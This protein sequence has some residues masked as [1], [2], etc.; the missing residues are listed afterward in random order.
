MLAI[1]KQK[2]SSELTLK[3]NSDVKKLQINLSDSIKKINKLNINLK[4]KNNL[5]NKLMLNYNQSL[6]ILKRNYNLNLQIIN[7]YDSNFPNKTT[8]FTNKKLLI[9]GLNYANTQYELNGC[10]DD[11]KKMHEFLSSKGFIT[12]DIL[13]DFTE[14]KPTKENILN[15]IKD[16][17]NSS[18]E[19]D[20]L[21]IY[22]SG[23][24][25]S[26]YDNS[27]D[28]LDG[29]DEM[30]VSL[31]LQGV[32]DDEIQNILKNNKNVTIIGLF[33]SCHSGTM[34]DLKY[35]YDIPNNN[36]IENTNIGFKEI[37]N[38]NILMI[39][40]CLDNQYSSEALINNKIQGAMTW[41][42]IDI[43]S[44]SPN[45][46]WSF[47]LKNMNKLLNENGYQQNP[48]LSTNKIY[49]IDSTIFL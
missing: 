30:I 4:S 9:F 3:F 24:G 2:K 22:F 45:C 25:S 12:Y 41:S 11:A 17:I 46:S 27:N 32:Y 42:F 26:T 40:G 37:L 19:G 39:S 23:H 47:L 38:G 5:I 44:N 20:L 31:D 49:D 7:N 34:F 35:S 36:Y 13:T 16:F 6:D 18:N 21:F 14:I 48:L 15:K 43:L 28:E 33:D 8:K 1:Y 29:M 10:I